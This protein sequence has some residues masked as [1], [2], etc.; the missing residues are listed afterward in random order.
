MRDTI[1]PE[2]KLLRLI[3]G[4]KKRKEPMSEENIP[5]GGGS[6]APAAAGTGGKPSF[7]AGHLFRLDPRKAL[8]WG[9]ILSSLYLGVSLAYPW[10]GLKKVKLPAVA[11]G[12]AV[13]PERLP[14][15]EVKPFEFYLD[16]VS[17]R[18]IFAGV[19]SFVAAAL[20]QAAAGVNV[21]DDISLVGIVSGENPQAIVEDK[22]NQKTY[23][24]SRGQLIGDLRVD[25]IKE[26]KIIVDRKG[27]KFELYL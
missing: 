26:G 23:Y 9:F 20:P 25:D 12:A 10:F 2:E 4:T 18:Q 13:R 1:T 16:G 3:R 19:G 8:R 27:Q 17:G 24:L 7:L 11:G 6:L 15:E 14:Q 21:A 22:K 5:L